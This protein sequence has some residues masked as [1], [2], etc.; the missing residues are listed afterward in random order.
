MGYARKQLALA[1]PR[2][3]IAALR[4]EIV[5]LRKLV[6]RAA[7]AAPSL[8]WANNFKTRVEKEHQHLREKIELL[9][10]RAC[11]CEYTD[12]VDEVLKKHGTLDQKINS[13]ASAL[14]VL[15]HEVDA[16]LMSHRR[17]MD[18]FEHARRTTADRLDLV[19]RTDKDH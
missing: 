16:R 14:D 2:Q 13:I 9:F 17:E 12:R 5:E 19:T 10:S 7:G 6:Y 3:E 4:Q 1:E 11:K 8:D 18:R 15:T